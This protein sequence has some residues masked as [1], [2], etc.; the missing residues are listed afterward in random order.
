MKKLFSFI[1]VAVVLTAVCFSAEPIFKYE[2]EEKL[3]ET[4]L[5]TNVREFYPD[6]NISYSYIK[7]DL[8]DERVKLK[9]LKSNEGIDILSKVG[10]LA[11]SDENTVAAL[12]ADFF[13]VYS[14]KKGFSLGMEKI[15]GKIVQSPINPSTMATVAYDGRN[16]LMSYL[17]FHVMAVAPNWEYKEIRHINK[18]TSYFGDILMYTHEFNGGLSPAPG[19]DVL[20]VVVE[21]GKVKEFRRNMEPCSIPENGCVLVVSEGSTMFFAN[22]FNVGDEIKFD[23]YITPDI[24]DFDMAFGGGSMLVYQGQDVGKIGDYAHTVAGLHPRSAIGIDKEG[25]YLYLVAVDGRQESSRGMRMSHLAE[26][27]IKLGCYTAVNLDGGGSTNMVASTMWNVPFHSV[28]SPTEN[29]R[30]INAIGVVLNSGDNAEMSEDVGEDEAFYEED[31]EKEIAGISLRAEKSSAFASQPVKLE[32]AVY[33]DNMRPVSYNA[34]DI[35]WYSDEGEI[36]DFVFTS[37]I[38]GKITVSASLGEHYA[39]TEI[40]VVDDISGIVTEDYIYME[41]G[42]KSDIEIDVFDYSGRYLEIVDKKD[43]DIVSSDESV[44]KIDGDVIYA[45]GDGNAVVTVSKNNV[46]SHISVAVGSYPKEFEYGFE[47]TFGSY[48]SYPRETKG[49]FEQSSDFVFDGLFSGKLSFDFTE[50]ETISNY[51]E[52]IE[53]IVI[54]ENDDDVARAVY[55]VL[56]EGISVDENCSEINLAVYTPEDFNHKLKIQ[57]AD[58]DGNAVSTEYDGKLT[59]GVWNNVTFNIPDDITGPVKLTHIYVLYTPGEEKDM[60]Y[61]YLDS[62]EFM[63]CVPFSVRDREPNVYR[64]GVN[65]GQ[66]T[67]SVKFGA[68]S[69]EKTDNLISYYERVKLER[70][71]VSCGGYVLS[72]NMKKSVSEDENALYISL[73]T[74]EGGIRNTDSSQWDEITKAVSGTKKQNIFI[75]TSDNVFGNDEFENNVI[76]DYLSSIDKN[77]F[78]VSLSDS[79]TYKK[80]KGVSYFTL[81]AREQTSFA[82]IRNQKKNTIEFFFG[83]VVTFAFN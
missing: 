41:K 7:M 12:N 46:K 78:V 63:S 40:Y 11:E 83:D 71:I 42:G 38:G 9:L 82:N 2:T 69:S 27:L 44:V 10:E 79:A 16:V 43:F 26:L 48:S 4:T 3:S 17:D 47:E 55:Y 8:A 15:D 24:S 37:D 19:G 61:I 74:S 53:T 81:D 20:E 5:L 23:Y 57:L 77:V 67:S 35:R 30:V 31:V 1:F 64:Y 49:G 70:E 75:L 73:D 6:Y 18:H 68:V 14:G 45:A 66:I 76:E 65:N 13:S 52:E 39:D 60:G 21:D 80:I 58:G 34:E 36:K 62:L 50:E 33:D 29:R 25:R 56:D 72:E 32:I 51:G 54:N 28:N 22:N 59:A